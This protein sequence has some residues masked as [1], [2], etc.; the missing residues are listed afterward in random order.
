[1]KIFLRKIWIFRGGS[2]IL[3][4]F[5]IILHLFIIFSPKKTGEMALKILKEYVAIRN[6]AKRASLSVII[7][8]KYLLKFSEL[9]KTL[10]FAPKWQKIDAHFMDHP[11]RQ[12][13]T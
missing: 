8:L 1:M 4:L 12:M 13:Q 6:K 11:H 5:I 9:S 7:A 3:H 2:D 10:I